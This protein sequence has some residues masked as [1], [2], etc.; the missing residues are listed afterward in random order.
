MNDVIY[1]IEV[2]KDGKEV[3]NSF[4]LT[5]QM[6]FKSVRDAMYYMYITF[7][8]FSFDKKEDSLSKIIVGKGDDARYYLLCTR[9]PLEY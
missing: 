9:K 2:D 4:G 5:N 7:E 1:I 6:F 3:L 8:K